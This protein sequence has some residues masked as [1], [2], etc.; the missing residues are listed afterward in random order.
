MISKFKANIILIF[1]LAS[2]SGGILTWLKFDVASTNDFA[3]EA[4]ERVYN[5]GILDDGFVILYPDELT[6]I[7]W[8]EQ[9]PE[10]FGK[11]ISGDGGFSVNVYGYLVGWLYGFFDSQ[12]QYLFVLG[13]VGFAFLFVSSK[14]LL[15]TLCFKEKTVAVGLALLCLSPTV[16]NLTSGLL[17]DLFVISIMNFSLVALVG[18]R[19][20]TFFILTILLASF[21]SFMPVIL[22]PLYA[23]LYFGQSARSLKV[24]SSFLIALV[25]L[26]A[27]LAKSGSYYDTSMLDVVFRSI[28]SVFGLNVVVLEWYDLF[29]VLGVTAVEKLSHVYQFFVMCVLYFLVVKSN[30]RMH[31][32]YLP[33]LYSAILLSVLY[34]VYL[35]Y[36]VARTKLVVLWLAIIYICF[37]L[38][39]ISKEN[40]VV[41]TGGC[42]STQIVDE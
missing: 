17:R 20:A 32:F 11:F 34:G 4:D 9:R 26:L 25:V 1:F 27:V 13:F 7:L 42:S 2:L 10:S 24:L 16:I 18:G 29:E 31:T 35:G 40:K 19:Y 3:I 28:S 6:Y 39:R 22:L 41:G 30:F 33:F 15:E 14:K 21:R 36:F 37:H 8:L 23:Y 12:W 38:E 5:Y